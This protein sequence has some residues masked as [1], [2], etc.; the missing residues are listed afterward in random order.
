MRSS[1]VQKWL[2]GGGGGVGSLAWPSPL[3]GRNGIYA[4]FPVAPLAA[5]PLITLWLRIPPLDEVPSDRLLANPT[6]RCAKLDRCI[7][8]IQDDIGQQSLD[9]G[10]EK[11]WTPRSA[12]RGASDAANGDPITAALDEAVSE[13]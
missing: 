3:K 8:N 4:M 12:R 9:S 7:S 10:H 5:F 11:K 6:V 1:N 13:L 2:L